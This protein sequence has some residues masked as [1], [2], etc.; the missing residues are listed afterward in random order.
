MY[1]ARSSGHRRAVIAR[2]DNGHRFKTT[3]FWR[4]KS[5]VMPL[6]LSYSRLFGLPSSLFRR[7]PSASCLLHR[8]RRLPSPPDCKRPLATA[9]SPC[10]QRSYSPKN[11]AAMASTDRS[12]KPLYTVFVEG[13]VGSGKTTFLEQFADCPNVYLAKEP[14]HE[15]QNVRGHNFLVSVYPYAGMVAVFRGYSCV[16]R[17]VYVQSALGHTSKP[18][19]TLRDSTC[20]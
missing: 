2:L 1:T 6:V 18:G 9:V 5:G 15:W 12:S 20:S 17:Q 7:A 14:V 19:Y 16:M 8:L 10:S 4:L 13:N 3:C 11:R